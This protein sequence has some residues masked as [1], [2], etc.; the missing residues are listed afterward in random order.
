MSLIGDRHVGA[1]LEFHKQWPILGLEE[2]G[3]DH[4]CP[5]DVPTL[6]NRL[7]QPLPH[8]LPGIFC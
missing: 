1:L 4:H 8:R 3:K 5:G 2:I 7:V 6:L